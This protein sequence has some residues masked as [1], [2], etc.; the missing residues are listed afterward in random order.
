M[1][2]KSIWGVLYTKLVGILR[3]AYYI[4]IVTC[5]LEHKMKTYFMNEND[6]VKA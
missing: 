6:L 1:I 3:S 4:L 2:Y 5:L